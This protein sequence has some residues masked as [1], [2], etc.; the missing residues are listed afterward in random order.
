M[1]VLKKNVLITQSAFNPMLQPYKCQGTGLFELIQDIKSLAC[2]N[3]NRFLT[4]LHYSFSV[5]LFCIIV[6]FIVSIIYFFLQGLAVTSSIM[7]EN[8][9]IENLYKG[10]IL[11]HNVYYIKE[12][13]PCDCLSVY[14]VCTN[15]QFVPNAL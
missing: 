4:H 15:A 5:L 1:V 3:F 2:L 13:I 11:L 7:E 8:V 9:L 10:N 14:I 12:N 6:L